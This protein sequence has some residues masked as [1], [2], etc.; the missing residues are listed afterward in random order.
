MLEGWEWLIIFG[1]AFAIIVVIAVVLLT[2]NKQ[3]NM[4]PAPPPAPSYI[5]S[6]N[7]QRLEQLKILMDRGLISKE[8]Y[9]E[10]KK[11]ILDST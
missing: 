9:E 3:Q 8:D 11:R 6:Q 1:F 4:I 7:I 2:R 10:Q 5:S